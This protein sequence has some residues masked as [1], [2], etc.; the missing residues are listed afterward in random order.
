M[1]HKPF[2][3][4]EVEEIKEELIQITHT[5]GERPLSDRDWEEI[6]SRIKGYE[7][8][9]WSN[10]PFNDLLHDNIGIEIKLKGDNYLDRRG[11]GDNI[12]HPSVT[13]AINY[14]DQG[15]PT[16]ERKELVITQYND[17][18]RD[19]QRRVAAE[20]EAREK[21]DIRWGVLLYKRDNSKF[22][23]FEKEME[24]HD[25]DDYYAEHPEGKNLY[26]YENDTDVKRFSVTTDP[27]IQ[28]YFE[29]PDEEYLYWFNIEHDSQ[30]DSTGWEYTPI[31][32]SSELYEK[33]HEVTEGETD[34]ER[35]RDL[36][37]ERTD[38]ASLESF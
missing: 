35:F 37:S 27:K 30:F 18:I 14:P 13:R 4:E 20:S 1:P 36:L 25:P 29:I 28:E 2:D 3:E 9:N 16:Q 31:R 7:R 15:L 34:E 23:Y 33:F 17:L 32:V 26:I 19:F 6:Y 10:Q 22:L 8:T 11:P 21:A 38:Q 24:T 12:M 5:L